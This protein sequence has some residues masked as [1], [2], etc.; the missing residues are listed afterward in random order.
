MTTFR[1][2]KEGD[3]DGTATPA[4]KQDEDLLKRIQ[5]DWKYATEHPDWKENLRQAELDDRAL[6]IDGPWTDED[7]AARSVKGS[8]R[9]CIHLDQ[10]S[11]YVAQLVNEAKANPI[12]IKATPASGDVTEENAEL[13]A[14]RI[15][16][17][18][19]ESK[20]ERARLQALADAAR[21]GFGVYGITIERKSWDDFQRVIRYR[22]FLNSYS[23]IWDP[24]CQQP[25]WSDMRYAFV[26]SRLS[27]DQFPV[28]FPDAQITSFGQEHVATGWV[29]DSSVQI[30]EYWYRKTRKRT[31]LKVEVPGAEKPLK[32]FKDQLS[33]GFVL[34][35]SDEQ[36]V[37]EGHTVKS[38]AIVLQDGSQWK[39]LDRLDTLEPQIW[40]CKTNGIEILTDP[41]K[42]PGKWIPLFPLVG[43]QVFEKRGGRTRRVIKSYI[44]GGRHGQ[45]LFDYYVSSEAEVVGMTPKTPYVGALGQFE[46][47]ED[48]WDTIHKVARGRIE[49]RPILDNVGAV[50]PPPKREQYEPPI[51]AIEIGKESAR[52]SIQASIGSYGVTRLD[53]TNVKSGVAL[54]RLKAQNNMGSY[55]FIDALKAMIQHDGRVVNDL[56]DDVESEELTAGLR[57]LDGTYRVKKLNTEDP[58]TRLRLTDEDQTEI[59]ISTGLP[60]QS[61][62][63]EA[64]SVGDILI[65]NINAIAPIIG[66]QKAVELLAFTLEMRQLGPTGDKMIKILV[67]EMDGEQDP[68]AL[69]AELQKWQGLAEALG[70]RIQALEA[71]KAAKT[72]GL[73]SNE[74]IAAMQAQIDKLKIVVDLIKSEKSSQLDAA[75]SLA[76][77]QS[78][79]SSRVMDID[80]KRAQMAIDQVAAEKPPQP[81]APGQ[82]PAAPGQP[83]GPGMPPPQGEPQGM[84]A[85]P[86][87][88]LP[89]GP[90]AGGMGDLM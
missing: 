57:D 74:R 78:Q 14:A 51:K 60:F 54:E 58:K 40:M 85:M 41:Q 69:A 59:T 6:S 89:I 38:D 61:Q 37:L 49:Y 23:V 43:E 90:P 33:K 11:Q 9:P 13:R 39:I 73:E 84:P 71:E 35:G 19:Y 4:S 18:E 47:L 7:I 36:V 12:A 72:A 10:L 70:Q 67:P 88:G 62:R 46:G 17:I 8:E 86:D 83:Q 1:A 32:V 31:L 44:R 27:K 64:Q 82:P 29:D 24:E 22:T 26:L 63:E 52:R 77:L 28:E 55:H 56:L 25:D 50:L 21:H 87:N 34:P 20:A 2:A 15:R 75:K 45:M 3:W 16:A 80:L 30:A 5:A 79:E 65:Q 81:E 66:Q 42:W 68:K 48:D 53:D 76:S